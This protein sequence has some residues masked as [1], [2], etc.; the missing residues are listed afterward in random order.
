M[1][2]KTK[3][4][5]TRD[6][7]LFRI[8]MGDN[9]EFECRGRLYTILAWCDEGINIAEQ[10]HEETEQIFRGSEGLLAHFLIDGEPL[11]DLV[12]EMYAR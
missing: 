10:Y 11:G 3:K 7:L 1:E 6:G 2:G 8:S 9:I 5:M 4:S 12:S